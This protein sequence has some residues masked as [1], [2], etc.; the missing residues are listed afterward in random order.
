MPLSSCSPGLEPET[1][2]Q[3]LLPHHPRAE[4]QSLSPTAPGKMGNSLAAFSF[5]IEPQVSPKGGRAQPL[6]AAPAINTKAVHPESNR[7]S[8]GLL[9][10]PPITAQKAV[11]A[12]KAPGG[13]I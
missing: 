13:R 3:S 5:G 4:A 6:L 1:L 9:Y 8:E 7:E 10:C 12:R 11:A 2:S